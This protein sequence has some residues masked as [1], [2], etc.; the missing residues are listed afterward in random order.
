VVLRDVAYTSKASSNLISEGRLADAGY[1]ITKNKAEALILNEK[2]RVVLRG[3]RWN[4]LWI[5]TIN[6]HQ[7]VPPK[8][9]VNTLQHRPKDKPRNDVEEEKKEEPAATAPIRRRI[10]NKRRLSKISHPQAADH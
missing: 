4:R 1:T 3:R 2:G 8:R 7:L 10:P 6:G 5:Y 9:P